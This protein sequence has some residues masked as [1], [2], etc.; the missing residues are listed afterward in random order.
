MPAIFQSCYCEDAQQSKSSGDCCTTEDDNEASV[1]H[2]TVGLILRRIQVAGKNV[3]VEELQDASVHKLQDASNN[4]RRKTA[5]R[6]IHGVRS[7]HESC[8]WRLRRVSKT[9]SGER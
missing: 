7:P 4:P 1:F 3:D 6:K 5:N 8:S 9:S 2:H